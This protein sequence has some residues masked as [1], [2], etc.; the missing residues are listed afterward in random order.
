MSDTVTE[1]TSRIL[2]L[3]ETYVWAFAVLIHIQRVLILSN[4]D[5]RVLLH[6]NDFLEAVVDGLGN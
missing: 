6:L 2:L 3:S 5:L 1:I 4:L